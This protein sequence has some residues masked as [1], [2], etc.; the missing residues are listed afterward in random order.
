[1]KPH[2][3]L[4]AL[5]F[6]ST[7]VFGQK[8]VKDKVIF[9]EYK[10]GFY[11]NYILKDIRD[12]EKSKEE[13]KVD[14]RLQLDLS[15]KD[16]PN[17]VNR[18]QKQ[19]Y[20]PPIS[21]GNTGTCWCF[22]TLSFFETEVNRLTG[23]MIKLSEMH[24]VYWEYVDKARRFVQ[25]RGNSNFSEGSEANAVMRIFRDYGVVPFEVYSGL[26]KDAKYYN[27]SV[28]YKEMNDYL[29]SI[30]TTNAW[31]EEEV[32]RVIRA[33]MNH[34]MGAPPDRFEFL[35]RTYTPKSFL[36]EVVKINPDNYVDLMSLLEK[37]Y[38][39]KAEYPVPDNWWHSADYY[40]VPLDV[41]MDVVKKAIRSGYTISIGGDVSEAGFDRGVQCAVIPTFDIPSEY[42]DENARQFR[43][44]NNTTTDDHGM[45][46]VGYTTVDGKDWF[47]VKD[48]SSGS[49]NNDQDAPEFGF[50]FFHEDYVKLKMMNLTLHKDAVPDILSKFK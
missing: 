28:M 34:Y 27:H 36:K 42:I 47:L 24:V 30:K 18:Y 15:G 21:Q 12:I 45:H 49:R 38:W 39:E 22:S 6:L 17:K 33:I 14:K 10:P 41:F 44:S 35:G 9:K 8:P 37:P 2:H 23:Q 4:L 3:L 1:M 11:Q 26:P 46:L 7:T 25:E 50:Y 48:S 31:D 40:N 16:Y 20:N 5:L 32:V 13:T 43:F 19:W 29:Q